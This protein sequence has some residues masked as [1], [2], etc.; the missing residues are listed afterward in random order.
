MDP[1]RRSSPSYDPYRCTVAA[2]LLALCMARPWQLALHMQ[3]RKDTC[4]CCYCY[5]SSAGLSNS[6]PAGGQAGR[7]RAAY[8]DHAH[9]APS[10]ERTAAASSSPSSEWARRT[11]P[12]ALQQGP[13][14]AA[15]PLARTAG[16]RL[17]HAL[18]QWQWQ[19]MWR[20][21][22]MML[23]PCRAALYLDAMP[24]RADPAV[25]GGPVSLP[26]AAVTL[27]GV[28]CVM[29]NVFTGAVPA[30]PVM[31]VA[32]REQQL[33]V[34][35]RAQSQACQPLLSCCLLT[36]VWCCQARRSVARAQQQQA[37]LVTKQQATRTRQASCQ[38]QPS[39]SQSSHSCCGA[40]CLSVSPISG[41]QPSSLLTAHRSPS[42]RIAA[43][44]A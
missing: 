25:D 18:W 37:R 9:A 27:Q 6:W 21:L 4:C 29:H 20:L 1:T 5:C 41:P 30:Q 17:S 14:D 44:C 35:V 34:K 28:R 10:R 38:Q 32:C 12:L 33:C 39:D 11:G 31:Q 19:C 36:P 8:P 24:S 7:S 42:V 43:C 40:P 23:M 15:L 16:A 3:P 22:C 2:R 13:Q 26:A